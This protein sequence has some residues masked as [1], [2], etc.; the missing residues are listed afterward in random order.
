[1]QN[2]MY[3]LYRTTSKGGILKTPRTSTPR[4]FNSIFFEKIAYIIGPIY[5]SYRIYIF[6]PFTHCANRFIVSGS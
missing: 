4:G 6:R 3:P 5:S 2:D 1:M